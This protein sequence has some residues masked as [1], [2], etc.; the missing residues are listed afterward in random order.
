MMGRA[1]GYAMSS[2]FGMGNGRFHY[3]DREEYVDTVYLG[4]F[5]REVL[6][7]LGGYDED[8]TRNQDDELNYRIRA[9]GHRIL[10]SPAIVSTYTPRES[11][12][13]LW[14][15]YHG[16][17]FWKVR[18]MEAHPGSIGLRHLAPPA[19]VLGLAGSL[20]LLLLTRRKL[21]AIPLA[22]YALFIGAGTLREARQHDRAVALLPAVFPTIHIAYGVGFVTGALALLRRRGGG[23]RG[24]EQ[25]Q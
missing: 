18:V 19:L 7:E 1:I 13:A 25:A 16:F 20:S 3:L 8:L 12:P 17:G 4:A 23:G 11:L 5:R 24:E 6:D 14:R 2:P 9:A 10:L 21:F 15:Q 22:V